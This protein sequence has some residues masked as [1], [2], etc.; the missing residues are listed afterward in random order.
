MAVKVIAMRASVPEGAV[1]VNTTS[2]SAVEWQRELSPFNLGPI[3]MSLYLAYPQIPRFARRFE[4]AWQYSKVYKCH[5]DA[6]GTLNETYFKWVTEGFNAFD[7]RRYPMG[8]GTK[9]E[10]SLWVDPK[11]LEVQKLD[12]IAARI[13]IYVPLYAKSVS[14]TYGFAQLQ[15][16]VSETVPKTVYLRDF[17]GY[18]AKGKSFEEI[19]KDPKRKMGHAFVLA[20]MLR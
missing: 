11:T 14:R 8:R 15:A 9:P 2:R 4:N 16:L 13:K 18:D 10:Y 7:A 19:I 3:E 5:L 1:V 17:D 6:D 20:Q 12:Y